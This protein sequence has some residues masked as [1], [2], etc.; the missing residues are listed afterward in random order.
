[1]YQ[2]YVYNLINFYEMSTKEKLAPRSRKVHL[3][4]TQSITFLK[5]GSH[6]KVVLPILS[7]I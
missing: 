2:S 3:P 7:F 4:V 6:H 5:V 1:M